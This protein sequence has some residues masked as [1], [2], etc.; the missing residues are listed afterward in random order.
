MISNLK[1]K[2]FVAL[3]ASVFAILLF[4]AFLR[5]TQ[6][7]PENLSKLESSSLFLYENNHGAEFTY[8]SSEFNNPIKINSY[9]FRDIEFNKAKPKGV[10]RIAILGDSYEEALQVDLENTWQK[11]MAKKISQEVK[12]DVESYNFGIS[13]YGTDQN[14]LTL[15]EKVWQFSPDMII[16]AFSPND[17]GDTYKNNLVRLENGNLKI[18]NSKEREGGNIIGKFVRETYTYHIIIK[19]SSSNKLG[20]QI[21]NSIRT[22]FLRFSKDGRFF[23]SDAQL[24]EGPFEVIASQ[25]NPPKEVQDTWKIIRALIIDMKMQAKEKDAEF[26]ITINIPSTQVEDENWNNLKKQYNLDP[27]TSSPNVINDVIGKIA[28]ENNI[29]LYD[30]RI[31]A[32]EW[33]KN[34]G[35]IYFKIDGHFNLSGHKFM[36]EKVA[37]FILENYLINYNY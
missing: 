29:L 4:E 17:V 24:I 35:A 10:Y 12:K 33:T 15:R 13:G 36:G 37:D 5:I 18:I 11:I 30:P 9:G 2:L 32:S 20:K 25:I 34:E 3:I 1:F 6:P 19:A 27:S 31:D 8:K 26:L 7:K 28:E 14:W 23:L 22:K 21:V 16:L